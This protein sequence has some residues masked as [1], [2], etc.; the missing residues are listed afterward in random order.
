VSIPFFPGKIVLTLFFIAMF[1]PS[2]SAGVNQSFNMSSDSVVYNQTSIVQNDG[3]TPWWV[4]VLTAAVGIGLFVYSL[5]FGKAQ[6]NDIA[7]I[8]SLPFLLLASWQSFAVEAVTSYGASGFASETMNRHVVMEL[9]SVYHFDF[10]GFVFFIWF[11]LGIANVY[12]IYATP[13]QASV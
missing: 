5:I 7:A 13:A 11:I 4:W 12:R 10:L 6:M 1:L 8:L 3:G 2:V 9:T